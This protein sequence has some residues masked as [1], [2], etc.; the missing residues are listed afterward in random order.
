MSAMEDVKPRRIPFTCLVVEDD[1]A[2][3]AMAAQVVRDEGGEPA[4]AGTL[5]AARESVANRSFDLILLDNHLPDGKGY[6]LFG[7]LAQRDPDAP[8]VMITGVPDLGEAVAL[9]RNG[10]FEYLTKPVSVDAL[11]ACLRRALLRLRTQ[12]PASGEAEYYGESRAMAEV[13]K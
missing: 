9:T 12:T 4:I 3:A 8:I 10:L 11:V 1:P 13:M 6:D 5:S 7:Q 2:F